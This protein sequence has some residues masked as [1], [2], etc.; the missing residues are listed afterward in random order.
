MFA[1]AL[2]AIGSFPSLRIVEGVAVGWG[3][4]RT[5]EVLIYQ[6]NVF[7]FDQYR[8]EKAD[9]PY[10]VRG[11][12]RIVILL[13]QNYIEIVFWFGLFYHYWSWAFKTT[14]SSL[15]SFAATLHFSIITITGLGSSSISP[16]QT[17]GY[18]L[19]SI[20]MVIGL[21]MVLGILARF[22]ALLPKPETMDDSEK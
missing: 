8:T 18:V 3:L 2:L 14:E 4:F 1:I 6:I 5:F 10:V 15:N 11:Y 7:L 21:F 13:L 17:W 20:Q 22:I 16:T 12:R 19:T 9:K